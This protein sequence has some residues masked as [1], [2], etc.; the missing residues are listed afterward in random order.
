MRI[1]QI[2]K[3]EALKLASS[4]SL[5]NQEVIYVAN[6]QNDELIDV[7]NLSVKDIKKLN[8][9]DTI[10]LYV[11]FGLT[12]KGANPVVENGLGSNWKI[13]WSTAR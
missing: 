3:D 5:E 4:E 10:W 7:E 13:T 1:V 9:A 11:H 6:F 2:S 12:G 8:D